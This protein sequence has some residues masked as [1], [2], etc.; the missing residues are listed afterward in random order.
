MITKPEIRQ[1]IIDLLNA[2]ENLIGY[3]VIPIMTEFIQNEK[4]CP[5]IVTEIMDGLADEEYVLSDGR[6]CVRIERITVPLSEQFSDELYAH[7]FLHTGGIQC[8]KT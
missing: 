7:R 8:P 2:D 3:D 5:G 6:R 1:K 4:I